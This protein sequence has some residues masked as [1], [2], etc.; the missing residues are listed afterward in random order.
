M[1]TSTSEKAKASK[2]A[3][4]KLKTTQN[5]LHE[6]IA[7]KLFS[8]RTHQIRVHLESIS[9]HI[10]GDHLYGFKSRKDIIDRI[11][12][13]AYI[14]YLNHPISGKMM[15]FIAPLPKDL[16]KVLDEIFTEDECKELTDEI[17]Q[18]DA[19]RH[20][21]DDMDEWLFYTDRSDTL[22]E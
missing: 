3:F 21:F 8:G 13:H 6:L 10:V 14:L 15:E 11:F 5:E 17:L 7:C 9:R 2:T 12:L 19:I 22:Y 4:A 16:Q 20:T 1:S 18:A